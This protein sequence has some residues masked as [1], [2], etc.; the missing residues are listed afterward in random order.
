MTQKYSFKH[1]QIFDHLL[2]YTEDTK[3]GLKKLQQ[4]FAQESAETKLMLDIYT[5]SL[6]N[7]ATKEELKHANQQFRELLKA[8]GLTTIFVLPGGMITLPLTILAAKKLGID[9]LPK[10]F[11]KSDPTPSTPLNNDDCH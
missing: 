7:H 1:I 9:I 10:S 2:G 3:A 8:L 11:K 6:S 5:R 4:L